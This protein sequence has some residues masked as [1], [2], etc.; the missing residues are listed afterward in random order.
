MLR[1]VGAHSRGREWHSAA[2]PFAKAE[3]LAPRD[4]VHSIYACITSL[5]ERNSVTTSLALLQ[6]DLILFALFQAEEANVKSS[7]G[8]ADWIS[9]RLVNKC[10]AS[11][12]VLLSHPPHAWGNQHFLQGVN[13]DRL[14]GRKCKKKGILS[15]QVFRFR[16]HLVRQEF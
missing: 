4:W 7:K 15:P 9:T 8:A 14:K 6:C 10:R 2:V 13:K 11:W 16:M 12:K 5:S 1:C 3:P